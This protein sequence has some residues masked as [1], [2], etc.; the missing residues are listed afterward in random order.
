MNYFQHYDIAIKR[1][2][3]HVRSC[4]KE[5]GIEYD[6]QE[7]IWAVESFEDAQ[8]LKTL[9]DGSIKLKWEH[10]C[11]WADCKHPVFHGEY[12]CVLIPLEN[13]NWEQPYDLAKRKRLEEE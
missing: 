1:W 9:D 12:Y 13:Q 6:G 4:A 7:I 8:Q 2:L 11:W 3:G 10:P 5:L